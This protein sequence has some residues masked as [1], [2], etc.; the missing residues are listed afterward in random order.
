MAQKWQAKITVTAGTDEIVE[1]PAGAGVVQVS[2]DF[3]GSGTGTA[4]QSKY[5]LADA[6]AD[7]DATQW[8]DLSNSAIDGAVADTS[9]TTNQYTQ[10][11]KL[12]AATADQVFVL[13]GAGPA[14]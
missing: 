2:L 9:G 8:T 1:I 7:T 5:T 4:K 14:N 11:V 12:S 13:L 3:A 6:K 10:A